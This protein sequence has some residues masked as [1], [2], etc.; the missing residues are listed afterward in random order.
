MFFI[1][2]VLNQELKMRILLLSLF[3]MLMCS[4]IFADDTQSPNNFNSISQIFGQPGKQQPDSTQKYSWPRRDL[5][6]VID[7]IRIEPGLALG[8][9]ASFRFITKAQAITMGDLVLLPA[10]VNPVIRCAMLRLVDGTNLAQHC[11][12]LLQLY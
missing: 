4:V 12:S 7:G 5:S 3:V 10:E 1:Y 6:V 9:W 11:R 8:S 2:R